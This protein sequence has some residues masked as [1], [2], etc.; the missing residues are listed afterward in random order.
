MERLK[1]NIPNSKETFRVIDSG[2]FE[3]A[4][5]YDIFFEAQ[6]NV[7]MTIE[8]ENFKLANP[9]IPEIEV[10]NLL[11][12]KARIENILENQ[13]LL[14]LKLPDGLLKIFELDSKAEQEKSLKGITLS[15][16]EIQAFTL[17]AY[18]DYG[19]KYSF[20]RALFQHKN[21]DSSR[22]PIFSYI[23]EDN[24]IISSGSTN[25][26]DGEI[27]QMINHQKMT[28]SKFYDKEEKWHC[29][30]LTLKSLRGKESSH[31][32][33]QPHLH[34]ISYAFG[35]SRKRVLHEL[36]SEKYNLS[37]ALHIDYFTH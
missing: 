16:K 13:R 9:L 19:Y 4:N 37:T 28:V 11:Y 29:F 32:D 25:M 1:I 20:Y 33:G 26:T 14:N 21:L 6:L 17:K 22:I 10:N 3:Y 7:S 36:K 2:E 27:K 34:Y 30:F 15:S 5:P 31:K 12:H 23:D 35:M 8:K 24:K 18:S